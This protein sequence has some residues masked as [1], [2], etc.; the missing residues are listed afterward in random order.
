[1]RQLITQLRLAFAEWLIMRAV[2]VTPRGHPDSVAIYHAAMLVAS[3][4]PADGSATKHPQPEPAEA[5]ATERT[6]N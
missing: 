5:R 1:M 6:E 4:L 3:R 2:A